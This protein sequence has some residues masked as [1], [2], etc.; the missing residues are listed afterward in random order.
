MRDIAVRVVPPPVVKELTVRLVPPEY[1]RL[2][3]QTLAPGKT[4][5]K[6]VEGTRVELSALANKPLDV[7]D[8]PARRRARRRT[9]VTLDKRRSTRL[10]RRSP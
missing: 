5:I 7:G 2:P 10:R 4:Q 8:A 1:T 6:A 9:P 3:P